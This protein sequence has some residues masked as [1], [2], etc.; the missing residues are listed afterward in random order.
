[1]RSGVIISG[2]L[3]L[4]TFTHPSGTRRLVSMRRGMP[5]LRLRTDRRTTGYD[6]VLLSTEDAEPIART[7]QGSLAR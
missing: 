2:L 5:L 4:G 3:K 6:E 1:M 7:M